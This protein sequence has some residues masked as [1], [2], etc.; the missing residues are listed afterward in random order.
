MK[1]IEPTFQYKETVFVGW[2]GN[3]ENKVVVVVVVIEHKIGELSSH[4]YIIL[5]YL[6]RKI[7]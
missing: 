1:I 4:R 6:F 5:N 2:P 7:Q 3:K